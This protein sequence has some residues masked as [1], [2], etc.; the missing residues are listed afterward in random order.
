MTTQ[1][2]RDAV[3]TGLEN[4]KTAAE[5]D[6]YLAMIKNWMP[7]NPAKD[8][9]DPG[10]AVRGGLYRDLLII[11]GRRKIPMSDA[12]KVFMIDIFLSGDGEVLRDIPRRM[13]FPVV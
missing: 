3:R 6:K 11:V 8:S 4:A 7:A 2:L 13:F 5:V 9:I 1:Q 12:A 10:Y